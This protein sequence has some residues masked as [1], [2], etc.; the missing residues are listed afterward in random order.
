MAVGA[1][2][3]QRGVVGAESRRL[4]HAGLGHRVGQNE[5]VK[6]PHY[7]PSTCSATSIEPKWL[8]ALHMQSL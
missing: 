8:E 7:G 3:A 4:A 5:L 6:G 1:G 2:A